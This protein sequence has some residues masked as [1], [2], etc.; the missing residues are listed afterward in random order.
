MRVFLSSYDVSYAVFT[1]HQTGYRY[2]FSDDCVHSSVYVAFARFLLEF[3]VIIRLL[4]QTED[5]N[6]SLTH[7]LIE[8]GFSSTLC[9]L[10]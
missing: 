9:Y 8:I 4:L 5:A 7:N 1:I 3:S 2:H 10:F 6:H